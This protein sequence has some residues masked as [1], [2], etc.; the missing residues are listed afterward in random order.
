MHQRFSAESHA[1]EESL[2]S[3]DVTQVA[4]PN[5]FANGIFSRALTARAKDN[6]LQNIWGQSFEVGNLSIRSMD[7]RAFV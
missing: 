4:T 3:F 2:V 5:Q 1:R 6:R 7:L